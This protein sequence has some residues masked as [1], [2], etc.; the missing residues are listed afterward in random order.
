MKMSISN[1][2]WGKENDKEMYKYLSQAGGVGIEIAPTRI[3]E[4]NPYSHM[5]EAKEFA[6]RMKEVY[7]LEIS[8]MQSIWYGK[9]GNIFNQEEADMFMD[10]TKKA[11]DF[12]SFMQCK[13]LVFGCP[14]NR[15]MPENKKEDEILYFF[16]ELGKYAK[17]NGT[18][19]AIEPNPTIYGTNFINYTSQAFEF[20]KKV[21]S[22]GIGVNVDFGTIIENKEELN[23]IYDNINLVSHIHISE[24]NL[25]PIQKREEHREF[26]ENLKRLKYN[27]YVSIEMK[28]T[29]HVDRVKET[30]TYV[31]EIFK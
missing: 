8:S 29:S 25:E 23:T 14:K 28:N 1:I 31:R 10:Y 22:E 2:A 19:I 5:K 3:F 21:N 15:N 17:M 27:K 6:K 30:I 20:A 26:A 18:T 24:P 4:E 13:N 7:N 11:I 16:K 12:A 9:Q